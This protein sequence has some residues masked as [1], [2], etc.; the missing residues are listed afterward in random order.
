[1]SIAMELMHRH[2]E[3]SNRYALPPRQITANLA[4]SL[5]VRHRLGENEERVA[6]MVA[7]FGY[8][9]SM[10]IPYA[11]V[12]ESIYLPPAEVSQASSPASQRST[13]EIRPQSAAAS[14]PS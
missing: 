2:M 10:G 5:G 9:G 12:E 8:G 6:T 1:M 4:Q 13:G 7:H 11:L 14:D 3:F